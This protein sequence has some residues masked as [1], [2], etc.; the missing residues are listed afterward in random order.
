MTKGK[1]QILLDCGHA[2]YFRW[3]TPIVG[4]QIYCVRHRE[5][6]EVLE[7]PNLFSGGTGWTWNCLDV[8][9]TRSRPRPY[10]DT[11]SA[12]RTV[13]RGSMRH[14]QRFHHVAQVLHDGA[15]VHVWNFGSDLALFDFP[16]KS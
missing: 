14:A 15:R 9:C 13:W 11:E 12:K 2:P 4:E 16:E 10:G 8:D 6:R 3:P 7:S 5:F 1:Y